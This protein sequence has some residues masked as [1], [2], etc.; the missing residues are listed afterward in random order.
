MIRHVSRAAQRISLS[1]E[2]IIKAGI[3]SN[4]LPTDLC[5]LHA[6]ILQEASLFFHVSL[7]HTSILGNL[8]LSDNS[9]SSRKWF[10]PSFLKENTKTA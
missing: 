5:G 8:A 10:S 4:A 9:F 3:D 6:H 1:A 2:D 7:L